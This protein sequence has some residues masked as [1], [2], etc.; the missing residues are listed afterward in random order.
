MNDLPK[1]RLCQSE[2]VRVSA[3]T[4]YHPAANCFMQTMCIAENEWTALMGGGEPVDDAVVRD[5][6]RYRWLRYRTS[7][8]G[9]YINKGDLWQYFDSDAL[10]AV[11]RGLIGA[12]CSA[13]DHRRPAEKVLAELR[14][15]TTGD[16]SST[17]TQEQ[18]AQRPAPPNV[19]ALVEAL[20]DSIATIEDYLDYEHDGDPWTEDAR[21]MGE[22]DIDDFKR[23]GRLER[24]KSALAAFQQGDSK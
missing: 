24:A 19:Q 1:C 14:R 4:I 13:I 8:N 11:P 16:L 7:A 18:P 2:P 20:N 22:M 10:V 5:A 3:E 15:Y 12:A 23:D 6:A 17:I 9:P 21:A